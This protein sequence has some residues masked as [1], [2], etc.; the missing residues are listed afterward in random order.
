VS[1]IIPFVFTSNGT[2]HPKTEEF[3]DWFICNSA[4]QQL[5]SP[6]SNERIS[7]RHAFLSALQDKT[8]FAITSCFEASVKEL[9]M[10]TFPNSTISISAEN[11]S[12]DDP[13]HNFVDNTQ[14]DQP[15]PQALQCNSLNDNHPLSRL[16]LPPNS[17]SHSN[18][19]KIFAARGNLFAD[20]AK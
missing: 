18:E 3:M 1:R 12:R 11:I 10:A 6:P 8:A 13:P 4:S 20:C 7:F 19:L 14:D 5:H 17:P 15:P 9:Y 2:L 16:A